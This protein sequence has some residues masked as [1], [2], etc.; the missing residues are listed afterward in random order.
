MLREL[1]EEIG[2][3]AP[4]VRTMCPTRW[5]VRANSL[6]SIIANYENIQLL[7]ESAVRSTSDTE[8]KA[9]IQGVGSQMQ[10]FKYFF[11]L[12]LSEL[13]LR[14]TDKLS[15]TLQQPSLSSVEGHTVA[16][17]TIETLKSLRKDDNFE[18]FWQKVEKAR[19]QLNVDEPRLARRRKTPKRLEVG[20]APAEF[21][22]SPKDEY[23]RVYFEALDLAVTSIHSRFDQKG[24]KI[25]S[26]VEQLMLK[27][28]CGQSFSNELS[29]VCTFFHD[30]FDGDDLAAELLTLQKLYES[31]VGKDAPTVDGIRTALLALS[32]S[33]RALVKTVCRLFQLLLILPA[34]NSTSERSFSALRRI[35]TYLRSTMTQARLN[36]LMIL[37]YHQDLCDELD[38]RSIANEYTIANEYISRNAARKTTF[39]T[40]P[41]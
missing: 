2:S 1:K 37:H 23:R 10:T 32:S 36:H 17:L 16:M 40:F 13:I 39:A 3:D 9:R 31:T 30:D 27:A 15:Q 18:L 6:A 7:W 26:N 25:F 29:T 20:S 33:Q 41:A 12:Y 8:M 38:I 22:A 21:A 35:K 11:C 28:C 14:H 5:T 24:Y 34:T 19:D 4:G